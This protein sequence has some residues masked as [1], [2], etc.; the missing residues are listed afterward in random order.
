MRAD[1]GWL[2]ILTFASTLRRLDLRQADVSGI[3]GF[4][5]SVFRAARTASST[6]NDILFE[7]RLVV[8]AGSDDLRR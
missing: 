6:W 5:G 1:N 2:W 8:L 4:D 3:G 7:R